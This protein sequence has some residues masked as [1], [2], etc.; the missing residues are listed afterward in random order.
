MLKKMRPDFDQQ[1]N[2]II[3]EIESKDK[4]IKLKEQ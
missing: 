2:E 4:L 1:Y 3:G